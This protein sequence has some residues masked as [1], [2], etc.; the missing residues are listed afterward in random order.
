MAES[1]VLAEKRQEYAAKSKKFADITAQIASPEDYS[2]KEVLEAL[3]APDAA[4]AKEKLS[5]FAS[6]IEAIAKDVDGLELEDMKRRNATR[7]EHVARL[8]EPVRGKIPS[9]GDEP[10]SFG[11]LVTGSK[12]W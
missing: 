12:E 11:A 3:A 5:A 8:K 1:N 9:A 2:K 6:E 7:L 4:G 10:R